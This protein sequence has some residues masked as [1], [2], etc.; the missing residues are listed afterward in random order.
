MTKT[1]IFY[2]DY[3]QKSNPIIIYHLPHNRSDSV[4]ETRD[5]RK[6]PGEALANLLVAY[7]ESLGWGSEPGTQL[8]IW[9][10]YVPK[11]G[12]YKESLQLS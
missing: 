7:T 12:V 11:L 1:V 8:G 5:H 10:Y 9:R 3:I 2:E 4:I 6:P